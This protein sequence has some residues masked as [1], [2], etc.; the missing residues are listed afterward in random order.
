M[1]R[2]LFS[3]AGIPLQCRGGS[4]EGIACV[5]K[6]GLDAMELE[7]VRGVKYN[8][9]LA[10][11]IGEAAAKHEISLSCHASYY[12]N[13]LSDD[14]K[15]KAY[16]KHL[17]L[18]SARM[19]SGAVAAGAPHGEGGGRVVFHAGYFMKKDPAQAAREMRE[20]FKFLL[21]KKREEHL[22]VVFAPELTGKP[23]AWGSLDELCALCSEF[24]LGDFNPCIDFAH[25]LAR[26]NSLKTQDD[27]EAVLNKIAKALGA[28]ALRSLHCHFSGINFSAKGE[29]N[30]LA[31][32]A[33]SPPFTLLARA[34]KAKHCSG[35]IVCESPN[36]EEDALE[37]KRI[38]L[39]S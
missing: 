35:V 32:A 30:H 3:T 19:L 21:A 9:A 2:V 1:S 31:I 33:N 5:R 22:K 7:Y 29:S 27:F 6:L 37:M 12:L 36:N 15:K 34:L 23:S 39:K 16:S 11:K 13:L 17:I 26:G 8:S 20:E 28:N 4:V 24:S 18:E 10:Q 25:H 38:Y 14:P